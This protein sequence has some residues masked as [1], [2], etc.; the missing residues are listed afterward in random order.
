MPSSVEDLLPF[1]PLGNARFDIVGDLVEV[2]S[3]AE[4]SFRVIR[5][6]K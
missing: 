6:L 4:D 5:R 1:H 2:N 3:I